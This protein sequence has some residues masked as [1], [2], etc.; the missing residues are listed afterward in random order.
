MATRKRWL[1]NKVRAWRCFTHC[2]GT[3]T[4]VW[5]SGQRAREPMT[6]CTT[7]KI[8]LSNSIP[9]TISVNCRSS[10][11]NER[12][13]KPMETSAKKLFAGNRKDKTLKRRTSEDERG[14]C[15]G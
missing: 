6:H 11:S 2:L 12:T 7:N 4:G 9:M 5:H 15:M 10:F 13:S 14:W 3:S 1:P 8:R